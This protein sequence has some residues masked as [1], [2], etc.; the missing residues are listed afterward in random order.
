MSRIKFKRRWTKAV[1]FTLGLGLALPILSACHNVQTF[2]SQCAYVIQN[3]YFDQRHVKDILLPGQ[4]Y[5]G[6]NV[7]TR[8]VYCNARNYVVNT[9]SGDLTDPIQAKT[10]AGSNG[11]GT[12]VD[13]QLTAYFTVNQNRQAMLD[14]LPFCEKYNCF[15]PKDTTGNDTQERSS[16]EG[17][18]NM[19]DENFPNAIHRAVQHAMLQFP[20]NIWNDTSQWPKVADAVQADFAEQMGVATQAT[21]PFFCG[22]GSTPTKCDPVRFSIERIDPTDSAIR[23]TYNQQV[24]QQ[25]QQ[26]LAAQQA[27]TNAALLRAA[28]AKYGPQAD[29]FL[30]LQDT[31]D[32]C[33]GNASC[34]ISVGGGNVAVNK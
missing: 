21:T 1:T 15:S 34:V 24:E 22:Q 3:G 31:I 9:R 29:Y 6:N 17:W 13:V 16:S 27:R 26:Q 20:P 8:Y 28:K 11:D 14:F 2:A 5:N 33:K 12:P 30:G 19:I 32:H 25:Y 4:R 7:T 23:D 18:R 10:K